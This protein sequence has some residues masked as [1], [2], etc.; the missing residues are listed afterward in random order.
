MSVWLYMHIYAITQEGQKKVL[1]PLELE[2]GAENRTP[3]L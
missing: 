3:I 1:T 2:L